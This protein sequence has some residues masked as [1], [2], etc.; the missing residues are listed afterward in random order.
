MPIKIF[1]LTTLSDV[2]AMAKM[3]EATNAVLKPR[4]NSPL[5][6][7]PKFTP[8]SVNKPVNAPFKPNTMNGNNQVVARNGGYFPGYKCSGQLHSLEVVSES[9][10]E[11]GMEGDDDT[12]EDCIEEV[13]TVDSNP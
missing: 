6:T 11:L 12:F 3:Q 7:T 13:M 8:N 10:D 2:Y 1:K 9:Y 5:L 4:Y